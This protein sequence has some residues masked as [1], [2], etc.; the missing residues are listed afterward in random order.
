MPKLHPLPKMDL[1]TVWE[2][3]AQAYYD[4]ARL[5]INQGG[6]SCFGPQQLVVTKRGAIPIS[7]V[8]AGDVVKSFDEVMQKDEWKRVKNTF[9]YVNN[10]PTVK[11]RLKEGAEIIATNDHRI[12]Y[13]GGCD[14]LKHILY[15][16]YGNNMEKNTRL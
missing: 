1:S 15:L 4:G 2:R 10:K 8:V 9:R 5:V 7:Q 16:R 13:E 11:V 12:Y 6:T 14:S 3:N